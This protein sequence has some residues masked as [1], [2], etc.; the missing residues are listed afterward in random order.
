MRGT[1]RLNGHRLCMIPMHQGHVSGR[2]VQ[3]LCQPH[4]MQPWLRSETQLLAWL[5]ACF[6]DCLLQT[7]LCLPHCM[8]LSTSLQPEDSG[9]LA[10]LCPALLQA[11]LS[12]QRCLWPSQC[13]AQGSASLTC[14]L[15][16]CFRHASAH[17]LLMAL[18]VLC[19][20]QGLADLLT[21]AQEGL[22]EASFHLPL[23]AG[24]YPQLGVLICILICQVG[25]LPRPTRTP[26]KGA[27]QAAGLGDLKC[28]PLPLLMLW[29]CHRHA[30]ARCS[31]CSL[32]VPVL[33]PDSCVLQ[34][35][36]TNGVPAAIL[37]LPL[38][39]A[40]DVELVG[41]DQFLL[42]SVDEHKALHRVHTCTQQSSAYNKD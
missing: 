39:P 36:L 5:L 17:C 11:C 3:G 13:S 31:A 32:A 6:Q 27:Q 7:R 14:L 12:A 22:L 24:G 20:R 34:W 38:P 33:C 18:T 41:G 15:A 4:C 35:P 1:Q 2:A 37:D 30:F 8:Q 21:R 28:E 10:D 42:S 40:F 16:P 25:Q 9:L 23:F 29:S 26:C 19:T